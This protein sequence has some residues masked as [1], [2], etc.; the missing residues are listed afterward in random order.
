MNFVCI[1]MTTV[2]ND[3]TRGKKISEKNFISSRDGLIKG[4]KQGRDEKTKEHRLLWNDGGL[5]PGL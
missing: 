2:P 5:L 1:C 3:L 4:Q